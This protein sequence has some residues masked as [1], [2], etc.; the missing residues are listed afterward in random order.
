MVAGMESLWINGQGGMQPE[1]VLLVG[2]E[3][4]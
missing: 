3:L 1:G 2:W 4:G